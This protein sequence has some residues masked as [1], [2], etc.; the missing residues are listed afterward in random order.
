VVSLFPTTAAIGR[1]A[2]CALILA[3]VAVF[4]V[5]SFPLAKLLTE[6]LPL[7]KQLLT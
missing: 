2:I 4:V 6:V 3:Q 5:A 1:L 7:G